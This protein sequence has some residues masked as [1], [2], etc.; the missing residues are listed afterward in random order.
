M[1]I[2]DSRILEEFGKKDIKSV[3]WSIG[4]GNQRRKDKRWMEVGELPARE[5]RCGGKI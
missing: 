1:F 2:T 4:T 5:D 3:G